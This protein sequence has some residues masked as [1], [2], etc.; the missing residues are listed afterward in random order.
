[1]LFGQKVKFLAKQVVIKI[2]ANTGDG[3][4]NTKEEH[5]T[6]VVRATMHFSKLWSH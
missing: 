3:Y 5:N 2:R 6:R 4:S 1:M